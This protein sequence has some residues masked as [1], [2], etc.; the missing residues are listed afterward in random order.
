MT[1]TVQTILPIL[2][3]LAGP[4]AGVAAF[5]LFD[6]IRNWYPQP[7]STPVSS[8]ARLAYRVLYAPRYARIAALVLAGAIG[9]MASVPLAMLTGTDVAGALDTALAAALAAISS[10][11]MHSFSLETKIPKVQE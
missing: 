4:G 11:V 9:I 2:H 3:F 8:L 5:F 1:H 6:A 10:Q 7:V